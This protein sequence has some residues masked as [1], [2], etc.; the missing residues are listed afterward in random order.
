[1]ET[2]CSV[3]GCGKDRECVVKID[4]QKT[5]FCSA[6][7]PD[8]NLPKA[9]PPCADKKCYFQ[10]SYGYPR[11]KRARSICCKIHKKDG[12]IRT[13]KGVCD[14]PGCM[15]QPRFGYEERDTIYCDTHKKAD[16]RNLLDKHCEHPSCTK[17]ATH[18]YPSVKEREGP[19][20]CGEHGDKQKPNAQG[21][22]MVNIKSAHCI[23]PGCPY[24]AS[25]AKVGSDKKTL[26][27]A[28]AKNAEGEFKDV[29][30]QKC[31]FVDPK[32]KIKCTKHV[33]VSYV[34]GG[35][36]YKRCGEHNF[37]K[38]EDYNKKCP[39]VEGDPRCTKHPAYAIDGDKTILYCKPHAIKIAKQRNL[40]PLITVRNIKAFHCQQHGKRCSFSLP[41]QP[42]RYCKDCKIPGVVSTDKRICIF[43]KEDGNLCGRRACFDL[44]GNHKGHFCE[45]H[46]RIVDENMVNVVDRK[47]DKP[48]C[49]KIPSF[50]YP[51]GYEA[52]QAVG[53][54][55][56]Q[57]LRCKDDKLPGM[58]DIRHPRCE[59][60]NERA[61]YRRPNETRAV[62]CYYC[63]P[64]NAVPDTTRC[65][66]F[67]DHPC[68]ARAAYGP[69]FKP[70][71]HCEQCAK[72][73]D[74]HHNPLFCEFE[75]HHPKCEGAPECPYR[76][77]YAITDDNYPTFC[78]SHAPP[79]AREI[80]IEARAC[81]K[82]NKLSIICVQTNLC[83]S[84]ELGIERPD[85]RR[86]HKK[87]EKSMLNLLIK[88]NL[89]PVHDRQ[90]QCDRSL[91]IRSRPDFLFEYDNCAIILEVDEFQHGRA[92]RVSDLTDINDFVDEAKIDDEHPPEFVRRCGY[93]RN[94]ELTRMILIQK[95]LNKPTIFIRYNPDAFMDNNNVQHAG[96][97]MRLHN[98]K[99][100]ELLQC[101]Q[102]TVEDFRFNSPLYIAYL[103]YD[104]QKDGTPDA[105]EVDYEETKTIKKW[106]IRIE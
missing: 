11:E 9:S 14:L 28:C 106:E 82:C 77:K 73:C 53:A 66:G 94:K 69:L 39:S 85:N 21:E 92:I 60:C 68:E 24:L 40:D 1:M 5:Y 102:H 84:C 80:H 15:T 23:T 86:I 20:F 32:T 4:G 75:K 12:M 36:Y 81:A 22:K 34:K 46:A 31:D 65:A 10:A 30:H 97:H 105:F 26:C 63:H 70:A 2:K 98:A 83:A 7:I 6:H 38:K 78:A 57:E 3:Q 87:K 55:H 67:S 37:D 99:A 50:G 33:S 41:G 64:P 25:F 88:H 74:E 35:I 51:P 18:N 45:E 90:L 96:T 44:P 79:M 8:L 49:G 48:G 52:P 91:K 43:T 89:T 54:P 72:T 16:M 29:A 62:F 104:G 19:R 101:V 59:V 27:S 76:P 71:I 100:L 17:Q 56:R 61:F 47:C 103:Y 13:N 95:S 42:A 93:T 58:V